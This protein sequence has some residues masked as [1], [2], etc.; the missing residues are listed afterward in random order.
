MTAVPKIIVDEQ[1][2]AASRTEI[3]RALGAY[4]QANVDCPPPFPVAVLL[5]DPVTDAV[6]GG[7]WGIVSADWLFVELL[8]VPEELRGS[9]LGSKLIAEAEAIAKRKSCI[10]VR[11]DTFTFQAP[12]FYE[13]QGYTSFGALE[14]HP[15]GH[16]R[17]YYFK[18][19]VP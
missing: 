4:N 7:L 17:I 11:L 3:A 12:G 6:T 19:L 9:G 15:R 8:F 10:G 16:R 2:D 5:R 14:D 1:P 13:K 18:R